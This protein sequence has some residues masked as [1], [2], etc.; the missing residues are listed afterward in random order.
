VVRGASGG[1]GH[2]GGGRTGT[3]GAQEPVALPA[4]RV[5]GIAG[6]FFK[7]TD[8]KKLTRWYR[9]HPGVAVVTRAVGS[10]MEPANAR[11]ISAG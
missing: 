8:P 11:L 5:T 10:G 6:V 2:R 9:E 3:S 4:E 7:A 1:P